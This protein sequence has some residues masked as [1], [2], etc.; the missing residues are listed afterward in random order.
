M[1]DD[2]VCD[3]DHARLRLPLAIGFT[4]R[5][6][7]R[8]VLHLPALRRRRVLCVTF[9]NSV[10]PWPQTTT[11]A[12]PLTRLSLYPLSPLLQ[13]FLTSRPSSLSVS[14]NIGP[15]CALHSVLSW[16]QFGQHRGC[17]VNGNKCD[18]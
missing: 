6:A 4:D 9:S 15:R 17:G 1:V 2:G 7:Y 18:Y 12:V 5:T 14:V 10:M 13:G 8:H 11:R 3:G 16:T